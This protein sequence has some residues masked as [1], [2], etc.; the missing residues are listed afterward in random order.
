M[1]SDFCFA[2]IEAFVRSAI[3]ANA[4]PQGVHYPLVLVAYPLVP[5]AFSVILPLQ[6]I[7]NPPQILMADLLPHSLIKLRLH[8]TKL[9]R[10]L[11]AVLPMHKVHRTARAARHMAPLL[12]SV[13]S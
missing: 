1:Y 5:L 4:K 8:R 13:V 3:C 9:A 6:S 11:V 7:S 12:S 2:F 10:L